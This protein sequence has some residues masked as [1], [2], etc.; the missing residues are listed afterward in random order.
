MK[1]WV[2]K[3]TTLAEHLWCS[4]LWK[5][6]VCGK[7]TLAEFIV[8]NINDDGYL[9]V[10]FNAFSTKSGESKEFCLEVLKRLKNLI[11]SVV[12][13]KILRIVF[14]PKRRSPIQALC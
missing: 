7:E 8:H 2:T 14:S 13:V 4:F 11:P 6:A 5:R 12:V 10:P 9:A 3:K 1:I